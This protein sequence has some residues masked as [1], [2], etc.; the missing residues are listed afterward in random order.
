MAVPPIGPGGVHHVAI[1]CHDLEGMVG[2]YNKV[3]RLPVDR[4]W[5]DGDGI[6]LR[7]VWLR[8]GTAIVALERCRGTVR[9][10]PWRS[11]EPGLHLLA[12]QIFLHNRDKWHAWFAHWGVPV[13]LETAWTMYVEDPEGNRIGLSHFPEEAE[14]VP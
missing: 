2:F 9:P 13:V 10:E 1:Q 6:T 11:E 3:L 8:S 5:L 4:Q 12:L 7:S 14:P